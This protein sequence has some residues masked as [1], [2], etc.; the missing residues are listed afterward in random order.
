MRRMIAVTLLAWI[1]V[2][3]FDFFLHGA[4]LAR[5]YLEPTPFLLSAEEMFRRIPIGYLSFLIAVTLIAWLASRLGI[6]D[7]AE[8]LIFGLKFGAAV[9]GSLALG[10][11]SV[12]SAPT[13]LMVGWFIGQT[14]ESGLAGMIIGVGLGA[15]RLNKL[16]V[17]VIAFA[18]LMIAITIGLQSIGWA[19]PMAT[20]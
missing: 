14:A 9:W 4:L 10:L 11:L 12:T 8:G 16:T 17:R 2:I 20:R 19:P 13:S 5:L 18:V 1:A 6:R 3:G 7:A 15:R